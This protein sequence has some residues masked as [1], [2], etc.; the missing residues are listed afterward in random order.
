M[1]PAQKRLDEMGS[2]KAER[3]LEDDVGAIGAEQLEDEEKKLSDTIEA[4]DPGKREE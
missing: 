2:N 3:L 4:C 1:T